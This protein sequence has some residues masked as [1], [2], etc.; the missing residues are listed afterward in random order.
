MMKFQSLGAIAFLATAI[1]APSLATEPAATMVMQG[2]ATISAAPDQASLSSGVVTQ[3]KNARDALSQNN[4]A[5][6]A[7]VAALKA[8]GVAAKDIQTSGFSVQPQYVYSDQRDASGYQKPPTIA[9]YQVTNNVSVIVH[10]LDNLG[11]VLDQL[12]SV[13]SNTIGGVDFSLSEPRPLLDEAR[14]QAVADALAKAGL[15][16]EA[17]GQCLV[18]VTSITENGG[19]SPAPKALRT[20]AMA[21]ASPVPVETGEVGYSASVTLEWEIAPAPCQ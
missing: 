3:S 17:A 1:A 19:L 2:E 9:G 15:Y 20:L 4:A 5:M 10:D 16:A 8:S 14:K 12:V 13:G 11:A 21:E 6:A 18:R 7:V